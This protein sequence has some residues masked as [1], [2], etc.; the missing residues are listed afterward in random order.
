MEIGESEADLDK[1]GT[2]TV[3]DSSEALFSNN[4]EMFKNET[5]HAYCICNFYFK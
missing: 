4:S 1:K 2:L 3:F 5:L